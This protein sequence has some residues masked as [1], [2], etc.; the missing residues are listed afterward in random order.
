MS[1]SNPL[2]LL[3]AKVRQGIYVGYGILSLT[4]VGVTAYYGAVPA[5]TIPDFVTGG[6][7]VLGALAAPIGVLAATN[8]T[9][10]ADV[11]GGDL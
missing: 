9:P 5:L 8:T 2:T 1:T 3:P 10:D 11:D 6:L 7:A 4:G